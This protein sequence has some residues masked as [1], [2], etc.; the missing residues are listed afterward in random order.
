MSAT[1]SPDPFVS[2]QER[3]AA[4]EKSLEEATK[5]AAIVAIIAAL[6]G[7]GGVAGVLQLWTG[8]RLQ[9]AE[10]ALK[11]QETKNSERE[12]Q[13]KQDSM[14]LDNA[15][16]ETQRQAAEIDLK[17]KGLTQYKEEFNLRMQ[18]HKQTMDSLEK[19]IAM[20]QKTGDSKNV[21]LLI[22]DLRHQNDAFLQFFAQTQQ[23][24]QQL[25]GAPG[26]YRGAVQQASTEAEQHGKRLNELSAAIPAALTK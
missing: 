11:E 17:M 24:V 22:D 3:V 13:L 15:I 21:S 1:A 8:A 2:L 25:P 18:Q 4:L 26:W 14:K 6:L 20:L 9:R 7:S 12:E 19:A 23:F 10:A 5:K 16:K